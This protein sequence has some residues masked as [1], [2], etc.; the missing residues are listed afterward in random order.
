MCNFYTTYIIHKCDHGL[1][2]TAWTP[3]HPWSWLPS[4]LF[5]SFHHL[6]LY[7]IYASLISSFA[8]RSSLLYL[9]SSKNMKLLT[10]Q[11]PP[12][13]IY[14][15]LSLCLEHHE[16]YLFP[17]IMIYQVSH[18]HIQNH[19]KSI[20]LYTSIFTFL[21]D[22]DKAQDSKLNGSMYSLNLICS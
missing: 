22:N 5:D 7:V 12:A 1:Q 6:F 20:V 15:L 4:C 8:I 14:L 17:N 13:S 10:V 19:R 3:W 21:Y 2:N 18:T 11:Y 16:C 9:T